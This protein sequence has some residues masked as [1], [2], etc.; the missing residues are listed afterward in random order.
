MSTVF[1]S[2]RRSCLVLLLF[3]SL[4]SQAQTDSLTIVNAKWETRKLASGVKLKHAWFDHSLFGASQNINILEVKLNGKNEVDVEAE[5]QQLKPTSQFGVVHQALAGV[6]GTFFDM[7]NGGSVDYIRLNG[8]MLHQNKLSKKQSRLFH[9]KAA[10]ITNRGQVRIEA[11]DGTPGWEAQLQGED[12]MVTGPLLLDKGQRVALD[13]T[14]FYTVRHPRTAVA[15]KGNKLLLITV[16]GRNER[17]A[18]MSLYELASLLKWLDADKGVNLDGGGSTTMWV[19]GFPNEGIVNHPSDNK[20]MMQSA[21]F[22]PGMDL[23]N[24]A[25]DTQRWDHGSERPVA[26]VLLISRKKK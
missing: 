1:S 4:L 17:A 6:N 11:W 23:D 18:G 5:P 16:D 7:K 9:Q 19:E 22:K 15:L 8:Q 25:A 13:S 12:V 24:F 2:V 26:N 3:H 21:T 14:A 10:V 20:K